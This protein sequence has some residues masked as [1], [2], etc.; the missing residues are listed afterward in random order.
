MPGTCRRW[1]GKEIRIDICE[2][3]FNGD[4]AY[5]TIQYLYRTGAWN[6][7]S[8]FGHHLDTYGGTAALISFLLAIGGMFRDRNVWM[9]TLALLV[10]MLA[11][12]TH[13]TG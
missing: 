10:S 1:R 12:L 11:I 9:G 5:A 8:S 3:S 7:D 4:I 13:T 6:P 2:R